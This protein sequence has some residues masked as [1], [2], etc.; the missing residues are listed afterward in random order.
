ME[1]ALAVCRFA[2]FAAAMTLFGATAFVVALA[3]RDLALALAPATGTRWS[4]RGR[5]GQS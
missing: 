5:L 3:P 2:H 4:S 1:A